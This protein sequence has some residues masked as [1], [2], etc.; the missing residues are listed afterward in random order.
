MR[1]TGKTTLVK[2]I[3]QEVS[4]ANKIYFDFE[5][6]EQKSIFDTSDYNSILLKLQKLGLNPARQM[7]VAIDEIQLL[8]SIASKA[9]YLSDH[10]PIKFIL[11]GSSSYYLKH[12]FSES[13]SGRKIVFDI[14]P[15]DFGEYLT[16][17]QV[18]AFPWT[19]FQTVP[20]SNNY[21]RL[22]SYY[23]DYIE[24]G[25]FPGVVLESSAETKRKLLSEIISSY[26]NI[27][28]RQMAD[29]EKIS[30][31]Q[32]TIEL[33]ASRIGSRLDIS[34]LAASVGAA[35]ETINNYLEFLE[36]TFLIFRVPVY[37]HSRDKTI[38]K[39]KKVY[40]CDTGLAGFLAKVPSG[41]L[42]ENTVYNQLRSF[43]NIT[44]FAKHSGQ[45]IDFILNQTSAIEVKETPT[46]SDLEALRRRAKA[47][48]LPTHALIAR[49]KSAQFNEYIWGGEIQ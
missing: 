30:H 27:D 45:E 46:A 12:L 24:F 25:G 34:K 17:K 11:T 38:T 6:L 23:E 32:K 21:V 28:V 19:E 33:L 40:F 4:S 42:F 48:K 7:Y 35:R 22:Q 9:K 29:F 26:I 31:L 16:F 18:A 39:A 49:R 41:S 20:A 36:K 13:L 10:Y 47:L 1:R 14:H 2:Q 37:S 15:L 8:P 44:Y 5:A 43:G 3:L